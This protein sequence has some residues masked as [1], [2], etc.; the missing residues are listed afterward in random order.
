MGVVQ[1]DVYLFSGTVAENLRY[2]RADATMDEI[3]ETRLEGPLW[4]GLSQGV[5][6]RAQQRISVEV[7][8]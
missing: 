3:I 8:E 1:Q 4:A 6:D 2:G 5:L 7:G